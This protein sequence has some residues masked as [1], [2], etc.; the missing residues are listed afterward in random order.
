MGPVRSKEL[1]KSSALSQWRPLPNARSYPA[2]CLGPADSLVNLS[3]SYFP[4][5]FTQLGFLSVNK[6]DQSWLVAMVTISGPSGLSI[7]LCWQ[8]CVLNSLWGVG[9]SNHNLMDSPFQEHKVCYE[10]T[11]KLVREMGFTYVFWNTAFWTH[12]R[13]WRCWSFFLTWIS[14]DQAWS[15]CLPHLLQ[16][17]QAEVCKCWIY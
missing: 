13:S 9:A 2:D 1:N 5:V 4:T 7:F 11:D 16:P 14:V 15:L 6:T 10:K 8:L 3:C 12:G 17:D